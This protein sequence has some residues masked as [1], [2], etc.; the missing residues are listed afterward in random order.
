MFDMLDRT[1]PPLDGGGGPVSEMHN[2]LAEV[3]DEDREHWFGSALSERLI[4]PVELRERLDAELLRLAAAWDRDRAWEADGSLSPSAWLERHSPMTGGQATRL[5]KTARVADRHPPIANALA[6]GELTTTHMDA[7]ARVM[8]KARAPLLVDHA[9]TLVDQASALP[10]RDFTTV[11]RRWAALADDQLA[12]GT[13]EERW[14]RRH[15]HASTTIDGW[16]AGDFLLDPTAGRALLTTLDHIAPPDPH[17]APD[18]PRSLSQRRADGVADL[19]NRYLSGAKL[20]GNP[21]NVNVIVDIATLNGDT[22]SLAAMRCD[23]EGN[24]PVTKATLGHIMC[25]AT[26]SRVVMA[27]D[28]LVLDMGRKVRLATP[29]QRRA[30]AIRDRHCRFPGC[31]RLPQWCDVHHIDGWF[32]DEGRTDVANLILLCRRHHMLVENTRWTITRTTNGGF[33][34][35]HPGRGP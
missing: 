22:P 13:F 30:V 6:D 20:G 27:G 29:A 18:G 11:M 16:V 3:A 26:L 15:F 31:N 8:S 14:E 35:T 23:V 1:V 24:G 2:L 32:G 7:I 12:S 34:F 33:E 19:S 25:N 10:V 5:V 9:E 4:E 17:D 28:S 21:P